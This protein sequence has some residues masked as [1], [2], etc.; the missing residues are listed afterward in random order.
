MTVTIS[1]QNQ[2]L[3]TPAIQELLRTLDVGFGH[4][5]WIFPHPS[6]GD[7]RV[8]KLCVSQYK[9][10]KV[11]GTDKKL[12]VHITFEIS[13]LFIPS[14][15]SIKRDH[16]ITIN[17]ELKNLHFTARPEQSQLKISSDGNSI[18]ESEASTHR[19][20]NNDWSHNTK[21]R[22]LC[23][24]ARQLGLDSSNAQGQQAKTA[25]NAALASFDKQ[26]LEDFDEEI[27]KRIQ[28]KIKD[29]LKIP[30]NQKE[31]HYYPVY[32]EVKLTNWK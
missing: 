2:Q 18:L 17:V 19:G 8:G 21:N 27:V 31:L 14:E 1:E 24:I 23:K 32:V 13:H 7:G 22:V 5:N 30:P 20:V 4:N 16:K 9:P 3:E 15:I 10:I 6:P 25:I 11:E 29:R 28:R 26:R 12:A